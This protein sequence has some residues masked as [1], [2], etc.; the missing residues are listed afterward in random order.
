MDSNTHSNQPPTGRLA[1]PPDGPSTGLP[2]DPPVGLAALTAAIDELTTQNPEQLPEMVRSQR[3]Q[4]L[5]QLASRLEGQ[6]LKELA[7]LDAC[8]AAGADQDQ[9][10]PSTAGWLRNRLHMG[11]NAAHSAVRTARA[12]FRGPL[13]RTAA[14]LVAGELSVAHAKAVVDGTNHLPDH[15][16]TAAEPVLLEAARHLDPPQLRRLVGH[17]C[18]VADP[19]GAG[20]A[21]ERRHQQRRLWLSPT[22]D[23]MVAIDGLLEAEAG[24]TVLAALEPLARPSDANDTRSG[25]Q[26]NADALAELARRALEGGRLPK[27]GG[28]RPQLLVTVGLER[29]LGHPGGLGGDLGWAGPL[30]PEACRRLACD[31]A[32]TRVM[33][34]HHPGHPDPEHGHDPEADPGRDHDPSDLG[35]V[36]GDHDPSDPTQLQE[37]LRAAMALLPPTLGGG[38][39]R[40]LEVGRATRVIAPAQRAALAVRDQGCVFPDCDRPLAWC[41]AHH[42]WHWVDGGPTELGNLAL[43]CREHHRQVHEGGWQLARGPDGRFTATPGHRR[44]RPAA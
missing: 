42:L 29:L 44:H 31:G 24:T 6:W 8:G 14:A 21:A 4:A 7:D 11:A 23:G 5:Q 9:P 28:I 20:E 41:D 25:S 40:P 37:R 43:V 2:D 38:P 34:S 12:L 13:P 15:I 16:T 39:S 19:D 33:V 32:V 27:T 10:A 30:D 22:F 36:G 17:L 35:G 18:Q 3:V 1:D 26:R